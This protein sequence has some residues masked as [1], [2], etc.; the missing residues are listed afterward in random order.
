MDSSSDNH[1]TELPHTCPG[2]QFAGP[3]IHSLTSVV[4]P[5]PAGAEIRVG[6]DYKP[7]LNRSIR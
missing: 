7:S 4:F 5:K 1:A 3:E 6:L 2:G